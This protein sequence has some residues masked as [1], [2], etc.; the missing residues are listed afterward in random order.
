MMDV[1]EVLAKE[2][3]EKLGQL[4]DHIAS[5]RAT[6]YEEYKYL[7]GQIQGLLYAKDYSLGLKRQ[8][9]ESE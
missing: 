2:M 5:G 3:D 6:N 9:E 1:F 7:C 8:V 4:R